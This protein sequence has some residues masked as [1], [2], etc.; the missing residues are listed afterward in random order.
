[1]I[2]V[3]ESAIATRGH[4]LRHR[5]GYSPGKTDMVQENL[6][7]IYSTKSTKLDTKEKNGIIDK[8]CLD[9]FYIFSSYEVIIVKCT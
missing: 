6:C 7:E 2:T 1:M 3:V 9:V 4:C 8:K 5:N